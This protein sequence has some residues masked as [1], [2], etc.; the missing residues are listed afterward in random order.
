MI[1]LYIFRV[2]YYYLTMRKDSANFI[3]SA[4]YDLDTAAHMFKTGRYIYVIFMCHLSIEKM[5]K[6]LSSEITDKTPP[7]THN[8][9]YL[10]KLSGTNFVEDHFEF[11]SKLNNASVVTR[12]PEDFEKLIDAYP[13]DIAASYLSQ[14]KEIIEWLKQNEKLKK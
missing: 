8:L 9:I 12:Y 10:T 1:H 13:E 4:E 5:L 2:V 14:T 7:K 6:A 3:A 11:V